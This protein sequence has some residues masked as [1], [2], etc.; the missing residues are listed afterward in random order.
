M[1]NI[2]TNIT[3]YLL[4]TPL[5]IAAIPTS[6]LESEYT[7]VGTESVNTPYVI[8]ASGVLNIGS[9]TQGEGAMA[10]E[11][12][13]HSKVLSGSGTINIGTEETAGVLYFRGTNSAF[14][15]E[16]YANILEFSGVMN[17]GALGK[18]VIDQ[19]MPS[20]Y[21]NIVR[22][23][24]MNLR[25]SLES[26][27]IKTSNTYFGIKNLNAY[28]G[29]SITIKQH[30]CSYGNGVWNIYGGSYIMGKLRARETSTINL[31]GEGAF[32]DLSEISLDGAATTL[33]MNL[34]DDAFV[35]NTLSFA[36]TSTLNI[37]FS[38]TKNNSSLIIKNLIGKDGN[39]DPAKRY[40][41]SIVLEN[42]AND[43]IFF[44]E[45][46]D[47]RVVND[48]LEV[49]KNSASFLISLKA[50]L[51]TKDGEELKGDWSLVFN[52]DLGY[53]ALNNSAVPE[54]ATIAA[55]LGALALGLAIRRRK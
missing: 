36:Y 35:F 44:D 50:F 17:I 26:N 48:S 54:P 31:I 39:F 1:K 22:I 49:T 8:N 19:Y 53:W 38:A 43:T 30:L 40:G 41:N 34:S 10:F 9:D 42:F 24:T 45:T 16:N 51:G 6:P 33:N 18:F 27:L 3:A 29:S 4:A 52:E 47:L 55:V 7:V 12:S 28:A 14:P 2:F 25:G 13:S 5:A 32:A 21:S 20:T 46:Y 23:G 11:Y 37:K 15:T